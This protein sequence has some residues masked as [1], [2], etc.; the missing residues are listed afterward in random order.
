MQLTNLALT[1]AAA[2]SI[3]NAYPITSDQLNCR[4]GPS[5]SDSVVK[6]YKSGA[7][8]KVSCQTYG[9]SI[10]G[11]T[12]W[13]K[14]SDN[15]YVADYYVKT[16]SDS[17]VTE[18][19]DG[20]SSGDGSSSYQGKISRKE[21]LSRGQYWVSRH[22]PY[23]MSDYYPDPQGRKYRTD[24]SGFVSMA[25][26]AASPGASTVSLPDIA[27]SI[28]W[29]DIK[30]GDFVGTLGAGTGG[31]AGHVTLF[32]SWADSSKKEYNTLECRGTYGCVAYKRPVGWK[33]G[34]YTAKPYRYIHVTD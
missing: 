22:V 23:S 26:H 1:L 21:I 33:V 15:C 24:C 11:N 6:T 9:E 10:N 13:D 3:A 25:L 14:T 16:G 8:V 30:P 32:K 18:S 28:S 7:D 4:S 29:D 5:T 19:C 34:S 27:K 12:I 31:A 20:G 17:M 2:F